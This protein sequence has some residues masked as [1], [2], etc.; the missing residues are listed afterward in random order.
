[1]SPISNPPQSSKKS[2]S[3]SIATAGRRTTVLH[4]TTDLAP[5]AYARSVID[6]ALL[7]HRAGWKP[8]IASSGGALVLEA[9]RSAIRH[10][11]MPLN[12][13]NL[14]ASWRN[15]VHLEA[16][17]HRMRPD[18]IHAHGIEVLAKA[19]AISAAHHIPLL[20]DLVEPIP[21]TK[22]NKRQLQIAVARGAF[23]RVP[24]DFMVNHFAG[25]SEAAQSIALSCF[26]RY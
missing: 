11:R 26:T 8:L 21:V 9:E 1:M 22:H 6:L 25:R 16:L 14:F 12:R 13:H 19:C 20:V 2:A 7:T 4:L 23:F 24:T 3:S 18:I 17:I 5:S 15:R 10:T